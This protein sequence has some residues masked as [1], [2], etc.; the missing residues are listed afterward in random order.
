MI[1]AAIITIVQKF[2]SH[3]QLLG[4]LSTIGSVE[5][6]FSSE[7]NCWRESGN[8]GHGGFTWEDINALQSLF[9]TVS[10]GLPYKPHEILDFGVCE[11]EGWRPGLCVERMSWVGPH[12]VVDGWQ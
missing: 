3:L 8:L 6:V 4:K 7:H 2:T 11:F 12:D 1:A 10:A 9:T 5:I